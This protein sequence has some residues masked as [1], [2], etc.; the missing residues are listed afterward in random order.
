M[1]ASRS[2][3]D[4]LAGK[5][6]AYV[7]ASSRPAPSVQ[8]PWW[9][10][11]LTAPPSSSAAAAARA[12]GAHAPASQRPAGQPWHE[13]IRQ[14]Q[15]AAPEDHRAAAEAARPAAPVA[16]R[17]AEL[18]AIHLLRRLGAD[19]LGA[20]STPAEVRSAYRRLLRACHPDAHP[21]AREAD[22][23]VLNAR[24]RA[25]VRAWEIFEGEAASAPH[26]A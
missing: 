16:R 1:R 20:T 17:P 23:V 13:V 26:A 2:F 12:Y 15:A 21:Q 11:T 5:L 24:L 22:R 9:A 25:V 8:T 3:L 19:D 14:R 4:V 6:T 7:D 10:Q 18:V